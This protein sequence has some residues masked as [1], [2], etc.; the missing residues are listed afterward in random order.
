MK[1]KENSKIEKA[2]YGRKKVKYL[3]L[4]MEKPEA[5]EQ[6]TNRG[7]TSTNLFLNI[8]AQLSDP[9]QG[10]FS[11]GSGF[12]NRKDSTIINNIIINDHQKLKLFKIYKN[13]ITKSA[14]LVDKNVFTDK[15]GQM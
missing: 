13:V 6:D 9:Y 12:D 2:I 11:F 15:V 4:I 5:Q 3:G 14:K 10:R 8:A 1:S 7:D